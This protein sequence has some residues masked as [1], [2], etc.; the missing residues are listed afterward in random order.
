[1]S[2]HTKLLEIRKAVPYLKKDNQGFQ[3]NYVSSSQALG[4]VREK[5]DELGVL[6]IPS[7]KNKQVL[8]Y[9]SKKEGTLFLTGLDMSFTWLDTSN[10]SDSFTVEWY[11]QGSDSGERGV[12][13]AYTYAEKYF[14]L[15]FFNIPTD[16][17]DPDA[18][19]KKRV[20]AG[21]RST[22]VLP[23]AKPV[24]AQMKN[25]APVPA[26][27]W[28]G[29]LVSISNPVSGSTNGR[30]WTYWEIETPEMNLVTFD[31]GIPEV[32]AI[33]IQD[34]VDVE[35]VWKFKKSAKTGEEKCLAEAIRLL[36]VNTT[37][38]A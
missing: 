33:A 27:P 18:F 25:G 23:A 29:K 20:E 3:Y 34:H 2:L 19:Q 36:D 28:V 26:N 35:L 37:A 4:S 5:M 32:C 6:L 12:G 8:E 16:K 11:A 22:K 13:K 38:A 30:D 14:L 17:D 7:V 10:P 24:P 1:M 15:K 9:Q 31:K 21:K